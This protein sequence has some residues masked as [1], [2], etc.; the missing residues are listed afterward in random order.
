M[1]LPRAPRRWGPGALVAL[2]AHVLVIG[3]VIWER[4]VYLQG[5]GRG[6]GPVGGGGGG[7]GERMNY[8][9]LPA[10]AETRVAEAPKPVPVETPVPVAEPIKIP[11]PKM[12]LE[13]MSITPIAVVITGVGT[14]TG[15]GPG[16][17]SGSGGGTGT[18][19]DTGEGAHEGPG[20]G[21]DGGDFQPAKLRSLILVPDCVRGRVT[22]T[23]SVSAEG[24]VAGIDIEPQPK[25]AGCRRE[26]VTRMRSYKFSPAKTRDGQPVAS[27]FPVT[28]E[29]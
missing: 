7:G 12:D 22:V 21:G 28:I 29:H 5:A 10:A 2:I 25:D 20:T 23:F 8:V 16:Q 18:G 15:G 14:G 1:G 17:E 3:A 6:A 26:L 11:D 19:S 24:K 9:A 4:T 13:P 27:K